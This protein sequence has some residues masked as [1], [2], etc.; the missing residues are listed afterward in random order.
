MPKV[1]QY[2]SVV[3]GAIVSLATAFENLSPDAKTFIPWELSAVEAQFATIKTA[4]DSFATASR[5][6]Q[7]A[8]GLSLLNVFGTVYLALEGIA[9]KAE[10]EF[11]SD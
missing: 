3:G 5:L 6:G 7:V 4:L 10:A 2:V 8:S 11:T 1:T 9:T